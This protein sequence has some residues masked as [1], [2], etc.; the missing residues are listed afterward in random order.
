M[1]IKIINGSYGHHPVLANG[2]RSHYV[3]SVNSRSLPID[4][5]EA[6]AA[7]LVGLGVAK[8]VP[9]EAEETTEAAPTAQTEIAPTETQKGSQ[10]PKNASD[11]DAG[12]E[13]DYTADMTLAELKAA[14]DAHG[15]KYTGRTSKAQMVEA[16][17]A[18]NEDAPVLTTE[19]VVD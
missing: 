17:N 3:V 16:L 8:Y 15:L 4:V 6:E 5:D 19:D 14:M 2:E 13:A 18:L 1:K 11:D 9:D 12:E 7:R 10:T